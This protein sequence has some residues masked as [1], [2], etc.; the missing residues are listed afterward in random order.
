MEE[1]LHS[2]QPSGVIVKLASEQGS[3]PALTA[4]MILEQKWGKVQGVQRYEYQ[5]NRVLLL[6]MC[7][8]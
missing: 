3:S 5:L 2:D 8:K 7:C 1:A 4:R 6:G